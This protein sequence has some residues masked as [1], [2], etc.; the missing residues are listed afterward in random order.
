MAYGDEVYSEK[1][2]VWAAAALLR[3]MALPNKKPIQKKDYYEFTGKAMTALE[4][5]AGEHQKINEHFDIEFHE[6]LDFAFI[7]QSENRPSV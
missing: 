6:F 5:E 2:D 7:V 1:G 3:E 4:V